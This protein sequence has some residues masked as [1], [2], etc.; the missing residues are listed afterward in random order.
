MKYRR[1]NNSLKHWAYRTIFSPLIRQLADCRQKTLETAVNTG[2]DAIVQVK[3]NQKMLFNDCLNISATRRSLEIYDEPLNKSRN[4][5]E[6]R[7]IHVFDSPAIGD[8]DK[9]QLVK[10]VIKVERKREIFDTKSKCWKRSDEISFY[11]ATVS[12]SAKEFSGAI[13][14]HWGIENSNHYVRDVSMGEDKARIRVN[15]HIFSMLRSFALNIMRINYGLVKSQ[16]V[17]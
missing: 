5:I 6:Q 3:E 16:N 17:F 1:L 15:P 2:N 4:R 8:K 13:R 9:W 14:S 11:I 12:L 7:T 10:A